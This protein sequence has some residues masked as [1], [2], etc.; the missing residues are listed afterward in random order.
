MRIIDFTQYDTSYELQSMQLLIEI[1]QPYITFKKE[2]NKDTQIYQTIEDKGKK[3]ITTKEYIH[4]IQMIFPKIIQEEIESLFDQSQTETIKKEVFDSRRS[5]GE[6]R[7]PLFIGTKDNSVY[8]CYI[9]EFNQMGVEE[10]TE[11]K[12]Y[13]KGSLDSSYNEK[14]KLIKG[15]Y[16]YLEKVQKFNRKMNGKIQDVIQ[17]IGNLELPVN[18]IV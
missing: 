5:N 16:T 10:L 3:L 14:L 11:F 12:K 13:Y 18:L 9:Q 1:L 4:F 2:Q 7:L 6:F 15:Q 8:E 17:F